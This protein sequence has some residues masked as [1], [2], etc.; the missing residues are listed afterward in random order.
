MEKE[1][2]FTIENTGNIEV[3]WKIMLV[4]FIPFRNYR[5]SKPLGKLDIGQKDE[6]KVYFKSL[7][8]GKFEDSFKILI[9]GTIKQMTLTFKGNVMK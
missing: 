3:S 7:K 8:H 2:F 1:Y 5:F 6:I 9:Q 4:K